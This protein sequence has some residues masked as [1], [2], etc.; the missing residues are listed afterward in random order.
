MNKENLKRSDNYRIHSYEIDLSKQLR[1]SSLN[2]YMQESA[3]KNAEQLGFGFTAL[4]SKNIAWVLTRMIVTIDRMPGWNEG[5]RIDTW[6]SGREQ[7]FA[8]RDFQFFD[9]KELELGR[10]TTSWCVI[11]INTR[12]PIPVDQAFDVLLPDYPNHMFADRPGKVADLKDIHSNWLTLVGY[13]DLDV[14]EHVTNSRYIDWIFETF[15]LDFLKARSVKQLEINFL[16]EA[17]FGKEVFVQTEKLSDSEYLHRI[18]QKETGI[19]ICR[20]K[21]VWTSL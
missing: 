9:Q 4:M 14:N 7:V 8:Y 11:D 6:P 21:T 20:A 19:E 17:T 5:L 16:A 2:R 1:F 18:S 12:R 10:A 13:Q 3:W 15:D